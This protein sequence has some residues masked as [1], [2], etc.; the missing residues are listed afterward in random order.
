[1]IIGH[2]PLV[3]PEVQIQIE[4]SLHDLRLSSVSLD[5]WRIENYLDTFTQWLT[6][7]KLNQINGLTDFSHRAY[8]VGCIDAIQNFIHRHVRHKRIRFSRAEFVASKIVSNH[9]GADWC[10][11]EDQDLQTGDALIVSLPFSG[12]GGAIEN[13]DYLIETC[14]RLDIPVLLDMAYFGIS[15][16]IDYDLTPKC[17]TDVVVSLSKP[18]SVQL[19]LG[20]R[21]TRQAND[22]LIQV[23]SDSK[24]I[25]RIAA[26]VGI[27]LMQKFSHE[28]IL[29]KYQA[30]SQK[31]CREL[32][33]S[34]TNTI[35]LALGDPQQH[36]NF[37]RN[38]Y[39][40]VCITNELLQDF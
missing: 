12:N 38:G 26:Q 24:I 10:Y 8:C 16:G 6:A 25:N 27:N 9:T 3:D 37:F 17:I 29:F 13:Y 40:R 4:K 39:Y 31:I 28:F 5:N 2:L 7:S 34:P 18:F 32:G 21:F 1:M 20:M 11:L 23:N 19:R 33:L 22:D 30:R 14:D 36:K 15:Y 35:T